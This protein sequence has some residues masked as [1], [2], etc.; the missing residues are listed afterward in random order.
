MASLSITAP[1]KTPLQRDWVAPA[2]CA[3]CIIDV[4]NDFASQD[5]M[6]GQLGI[7]MQ[8]LSPALA[9][10]N[11]LQQ[12]A[13][14]ADVPVIFIGLATSAAQDSASWK[15]RIARL[16]G[17]PEAE[18]AICREGTPGAEF[19]FCLPAPTDKVIFKTR[20]SGFWQTGLQDYLQSLG[21]DTL[22]MTGITT[23]C[24]VESTVRDAFHLDYHVFVPEDACAAYEPALH[25]GSLA[26]MAMSF[27]LITD[28]SSI[29]RFW[30]E[31]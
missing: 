12:A 3:L 2:R 18:I 10:I 7:D 29:T 1:A 8:V 5:Y 24:C 11:L 22:I 15:T 30:R 28:T 13:H 23:E 4:Q 16:G 9:N 25:A 19:C 14:Q 21:V 26:G 6:L 31:A 20:Y 27:A 17:N